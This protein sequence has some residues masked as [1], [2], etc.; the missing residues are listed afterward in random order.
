MT[1]YV[2]AYQEP[3]SV[4][5]GEACRLGARLAHDATS[6]E[7]VMRWNSNNQVPPGDVVALAAFLG[8]PVAITMCDTVR[9]AELSAF[10]AEVRA[11]DRGPTAE[12][13][14]EARAAHGPGVTIR[15][16]ITG[17]EFRT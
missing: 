8:H 15:N 14:A 16:V 5:H 12:Q 17:R 1:D 7:G 13:I 9:A 11:R 10:L 3:G 2:R 4:Y 6:H